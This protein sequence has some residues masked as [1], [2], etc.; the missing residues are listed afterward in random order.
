[1]ISL[2]EDEPVHALEGEGGPSIL[3]SPFASTSL[4]LSIRQR[5]DYT[6]YRHIFQQFLRISQAHT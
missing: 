6:I 4:V 5:F 1:M 3:A 2:K